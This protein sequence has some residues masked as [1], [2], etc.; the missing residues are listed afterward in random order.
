MVSKAGEAAGEVEESGGSDRRRGYGMGGIWV[1]G[2]R[3]GWVL[4]LE[5]TGLGGWVPHAK[6]K[7]FY[8]YF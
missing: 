4:G 6:K 3:D 5:K 2:R 7:I 1:W 8:F